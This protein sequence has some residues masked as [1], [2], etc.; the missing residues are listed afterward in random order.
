[1]A[2]K[3][4]QTDITRMNE[5]YLTLKTYAAVA[6]EVGFS[7]STVSKYIVSGYKS[8]AERLKNRTPF[9]GEIKPL[10]PERIDAFKTLRGH[11]GL[12]C[13]LTEEEKEGMKT[14]YDEV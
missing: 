13:E 14:L 7:A 6:R 2:N 11:W 10:T 3:V 9:T 5:L 12:M 8:V 4:T 1:M